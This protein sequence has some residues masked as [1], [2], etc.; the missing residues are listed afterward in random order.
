MKMNKTLKQFFDE[1]IQLEL[2]VAGLYTIF[3]RAFPNDAVFWGRLVVEEKNHASLIKDGKV[4]F[5]A[6]D[7]FP[8]EMLAS[9]LEE[10]I[11]ANSTIVKLLEKHQDTPPSQEDAFNLALKL[12]QS[13]GEVHFQQF[14]EK[15]SGSKLDSIFKRL[16]RN[17][18]D[19]A[20]RILS[21][22]K[23]QGIEIKE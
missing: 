11:S 10:L 3:Q 8:L 9:S 20:M 18:K 21:Y 13:A 6:L 23:D 22:M 19:H 14:M 4:R 16:N 5:E 1:T 2:N 7:K 15:S 12:E 17:D